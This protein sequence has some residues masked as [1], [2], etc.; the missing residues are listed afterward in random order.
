M[1]QAALQ[2]SQIIAK[3]S[4]DNE[5]IERKFAAWDGRRSI[6]LEMPQGSIGLATA[7]YS[8]DL[9]H[10]ERC[11]VAQRLAA[12]WNLAAAYGWDTMTI[13]GLLAKKLASEA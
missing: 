12:L 9:T 8:Y 7:T 11:D 4:G 6:R 10:E 3:R 2:V 5:P 1:D 13:E